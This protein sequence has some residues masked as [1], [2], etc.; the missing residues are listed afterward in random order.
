[1]IDFVDRV[2]TYANRMKVTPESGSAFYATIERADVPI[3][4]G[5][6]L[7]AETFNGLQADVGV[8]TYTHS[9]SSAGVHDFVGSG[10]NGKA[11][12]TAAFSA[13]DKFS[14]NGLAVAGAF[15]GAE[16]ADGSVIVN[17]RWVTF[18][19][20]EER[21][22]LNFKGGGGLTSTKLSTATAQ[23]A[24]V[25]D[26]KTFYAGNK[27]LK[28]GTLPHFPEYYNYADKVV[29]GDYVA[30][31]LKRG[32][33]TN[34][35]NTY[36]RASKADVV[37]AIGLTAAKLVKGNTVLGVAG[38]AVP[39]QV[40]DFVGT[41]LVGAT[42]FKTGTLP[43]GTYKVVG[44]SVRDGSSG[45]GQ[46]G[47]LA[48]YVGGTQKVTGTNTASNFGCTISGTFTLTESSSVSI[49]QIAGTAGDASTAQSV[50]I[51][52]TA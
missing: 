1:M 17:G 9:R 6:P 51:Y 2:P 22:T 10:S 30:Y 29:V 37:D 18:T 28:T 13:G 50:V 42:T 3:T 38:S 48:V 15:C 45:T 20:D 43:A 40:L 8:M 23:D 14:V 34:V 35:E 49:R 36:I 27:E 19:Y 16:A 25:L 33:Y 41:S 11:Y 39:M 7:N 46:C 5:T 47:L 24:H 4:E 32:A 26:G 12:I 21:N 31:L 52:R 44:C